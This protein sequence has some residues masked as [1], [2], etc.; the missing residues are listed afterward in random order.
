MTPKY[1]FAPRASNLGQTRQL[2]NLGSKGYIQGYNAQAVVT[3]DQVIVACD[4]VREANDV[5]QFKPMVE[6]AKGALEEIGE[7]PVTVLADAGYCTE[8]NMEYAERQG[9][10]KCLIAT[11]KE[12]RLGKASK[13]RGGADPRGAQGCPERLKS[14]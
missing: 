9:D 11:G 4:V 6:K 8:A 7:E 5:H 14:L 12:S 13:Q 3:K 10:I 1:V 2:H